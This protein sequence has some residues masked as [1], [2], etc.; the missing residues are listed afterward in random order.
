[1][2]PSLAAWNAD[3]AKLE[4]KVNE[5]GGCR[6]HLGDSAARLKACLDLDAEIN[7]LYARLGTYSGELL[8]ENTAVA[9]SQE[10]DQRGDVLEIASAKQPHSCDPRSWRWAPRK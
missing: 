10:L 8:A 3:A 6:G 1:M 4:S 7:K 9:S 5:F 2:Y